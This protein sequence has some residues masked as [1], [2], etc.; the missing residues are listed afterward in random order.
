MLGS[1]TRLIPV[2]FMRA[3][4]IAQVDILPNV[5]IWA[6]DTLDVLSQATSVLTFNNPGL[7]I[8]F[9][10]GESDATATTRIGT[11]VLISAGGDITID[12]K[13]D[14]TLDVSTSIVSGLTVAKKKKNSSSDVRGMKRVKGP[15]IAMTLGDATTTSL[16][17]IGE[18]SLIT[19]VN[20]TI[21]STTVTHQ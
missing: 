14:N 12:S 10:F 16:T 20:V 5:S 11:D 13:A 6:E 15:A 2:H 3:A 17:D 18:S 1:L 21:D 7:N 4:A 9:T 19:G 8:G